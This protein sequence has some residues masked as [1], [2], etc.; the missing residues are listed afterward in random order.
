MSTMPCWERT[1]SASSVRIWGHSP[2]DFGAAKAWTCTLA[3]PSSSVTATTRW[4]F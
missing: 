4:D 2:R 3:C 1:D